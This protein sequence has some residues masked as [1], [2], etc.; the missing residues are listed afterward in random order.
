MKIPLN[1]SALPLLSAMAS[2]TRISIIEELSKHKMNVGEL[3]QALGISQ[4]VT[5]KHVEILARAGI[6][7]TQRL[8]GKQ[9]M[10]K[11]SVLRIDN[12]DFV[13]PRKVNMAYESSSISMP[14]G[15]YT[16]CIIKP[17]C[18]LATPKGIIG[19]LDDPRFFMDPQRFQAAILW[20]TTGYV[21]YNLVNTMKDGRKLKMVDISMELGSEFPLGNNNWPS[22]IS[23]TFNGIGI[24]SW[25][26]P[27]DFID[28]HGYYNPDWYHSDL[29]QYGIKVTLRLTN[30]GC[31]VNGQR[32]TKL[33]FEQLKIFQ[34]VWTFRIGVKEDAEHP[35]GCTIY[36]RGF[37][38][39]DQNIEV[40]SYYSDEGNESLTYN[41][42]RKTKKR[43]PNLGMPNNLA[44]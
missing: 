22:T 41:E 16:Q 4:P 44:E 27:G 36:G 10:Q 34:P 21:E 8:P 14:I 40:K 18:G 13:F 1:Q 42:D 32:T 35:G 37:G 12:V 19:E 2:K 38:D 30:D 7:K 31:W 39:Y 33:N 28:K 29:N 11:Q 5:A 43:D 26:S 3:A 23:F 24:A 6:I 9:G 15:Q 20:F 17:T 25:T